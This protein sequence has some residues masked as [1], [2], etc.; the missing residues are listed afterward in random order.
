MDDKR[1]AELKGGYR[2]PFDP[3]PL[4]V[5][6]EINDNAEEAWCELWGELYHQGD[7][8]EASFAAVPQ[9]VRIYRT[10]GTVDWNT[11]AIAGMIELARHEGKN[12]DVPKWLEQEYF[13]AL[14][15]LAEI[16][17]REILLADNLEEIRAILG[18][19]A[20]VKGARTHAR[21]LLDYSDDEMLEF[22]SKL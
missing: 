15:D 13:Q 16:G 18:V 7:V 2:M 21:F 19:L 17:A 20:L 5:K 10:R 22:E 8:G 14:R 6:I 1:W 4:L 3:R 11:Y 9:L 12:P